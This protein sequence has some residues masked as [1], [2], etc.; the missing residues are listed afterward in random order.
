MDARSAWPDGQAVINFSAFD[1]RGDP[2]L[3][4]LELAAGRMTGNAG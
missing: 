2:M 1:K 4:R 3:L